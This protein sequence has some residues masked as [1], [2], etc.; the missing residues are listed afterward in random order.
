[1]PANSLGHFDIKTMLVFVSL[2]FAEDSILVQQKPV[3]LC[4]QAIPS[5]NP[6]KKTRFCNKQSTKQI[7]YK[8]SYESR[9]S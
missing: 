4:R 6:L 1:M 7:L 2:A 8:G 5:R 3:L 9:P